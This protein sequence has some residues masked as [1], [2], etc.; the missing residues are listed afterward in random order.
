[1]PR[2]AARPSE[3]GKHLF[4]NAFKLGAHLPKHCFVNLQYCVLW[5]FGPHI[6]MVFGL[7]GAVL[8]FLFRREN[9]VVKPLR[10]FLDI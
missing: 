10:D 4:D 7:N 6:R 3:S 1:M 8:A 2:V 5:A 9:E